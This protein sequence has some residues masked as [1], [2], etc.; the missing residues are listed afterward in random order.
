MGFILPTIHSTKDLPT[1]TPTNTPTPS[2]TS[3]PVTGYGYNLVVLPYN[4]PSSGN[5]IF[6]TF[7]TPG[8]NSGTTNPNT[9]T[10]NAI[11]WNAT[12]NLG[13]D[14]SNYY[15]GMTGVSVTAY[16]TQNGHTLIY[17]GSPTAFTYDGSP[18]AFNYNPNARPNQL[19]LIQSA[20]TNFVTGQTVYISFVVNIA[21]H[22]LQRQLTPKPQHLQ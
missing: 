11:Y 18:L 22:R 17:S 7:A 6:P 1:V 8:L 10:T 2:T 12:D 21:R 19:V 9:F 4:P 20:N 13:F 5:T 16:F 15:S 3:S 14:R